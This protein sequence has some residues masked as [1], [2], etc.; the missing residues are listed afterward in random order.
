[1][2]IDV[3]GHCRSV[4]PVPLTPLS[5]AALDRCL[6]FRVDLPLA[7]HAAALARRTVA[8]VLS[9]WQVVDEEWVYDV[10]L[11]CSELV[12]NAVRHGGK[13]VELALTLGD[14]Q[15]LVE[16][17]D[18]SSVVPEQRADAEEES[19][20]GLAIIDALADRWGASTHGE[21]KTVWAAVRSP[22]VPTQRPGGRADHGPK[23]VAQ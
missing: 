19:G 12:G 7:E 11:L 13:R 5:P 18:G 1:M 22:A 9:G 10:Q 6:A 3:N 21:G 23:P 20:R 4:P 8:D 17:S 2:A 14:A 16:V 15:L